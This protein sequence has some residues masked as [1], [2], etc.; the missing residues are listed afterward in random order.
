MKQPDKLKRHFL[1]IVII[2]S[3]LLFFFGQLMMYPILT[4]CQANIS[5]AGTVF[6]LEYSICLGWECKFNV[7]QYLS[8]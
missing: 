4:F 6:L 3:F 8:I 2:I 5:D 7:F 1:L